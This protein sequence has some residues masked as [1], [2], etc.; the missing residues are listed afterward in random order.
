VTAEQFAAAV[1]RLH[2]HVSH[3]T[4]PRWAAFGASG[5][6][7]AEMVHT[8]VQRL[9]ELSA[10]AEGEPRRAVPRLD[11]DL[12]LADQLRVV[13]ADLV[14]AGPDDEVLARAT[15]LVTTT[16]RGLGGSPPGR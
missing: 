5:V 15:E 6:P 9:A 1:R 2:G 3:W 14:A 11:S 12:V 7:R 4:P 13:A 16:H 8:L 10:D